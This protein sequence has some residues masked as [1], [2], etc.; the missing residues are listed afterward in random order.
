MFDPQKEPYDN[1]VTLFGEAHRLKVNEPTAMSLGTVSKDHKPSVRIVYCKQHSPEGFV[2][3][4]NY[5]GAKAS[6]IVDNP[7]VCLNF[8]YAELWQQIRIDGVA[9]K[10]S[11]KASEDYFATRARLSQIGAWASQQSQKLESKNHFQE[12]IQFFEKKF[13]N[14]T[15]PCPPHWGGYL[16]RPEKIEFWFGNDGR[17]HERYVYEKTAGSQWSH[18]LLNP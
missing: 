6:D 18:Y 8:Y 13:E 1:F 3:F 15:V 2:F 4:T 10:I 9:E 16:V 17:L 5:Q 7:N 14:Q 11:R 12:Q